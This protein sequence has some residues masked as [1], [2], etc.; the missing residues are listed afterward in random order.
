M[1]SKYLRRE[2]NFWNA[3]FLSSLNDATF[4]HLPE[5]PTK[6]QLCRQIA[7]IYVYILF[8]TMLFLFLSLLFAW[9]YVLWICKHLVSVKSLI[10][11]EKNGRMPVRS[12]FSD[13]SFKLTNIKILISYFGILTNRLSNPSSCFVS[14]EDRFQ[15]PISRNML[16][17][18]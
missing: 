11:V 16:C 7:S 4:L 8:I 13:K 17:H 5:D 10:S 18:H 1:W 2:G 12:K 3:S 15:L 14:N 6:G 9:C